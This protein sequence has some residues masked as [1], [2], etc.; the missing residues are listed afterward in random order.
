[1]LV[2]SNGDTQRS[3]TLLWSSGSSRGPSSVL[4]CGM[5][6]ASRVP[7]AC[8]HFPDKAGTLTHAIYCCRILPKSCCLTGVIHLVLQPWAKESELLKPPTERREQRGVAVLWGA[9]A[10]MNSEALA[11]LLGRTLWRWWIHN[12]HL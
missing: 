6:K 3:G 10:G 1:M 11:D 8:T 2:L 5:M 9:D 7:L 12:G 4:L